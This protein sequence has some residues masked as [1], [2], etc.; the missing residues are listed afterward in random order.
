[1]PPVRQKLFWS[2]LRYGGVIPRLILARTRVLVGAFP[3][4]SQGGVHSIVRMPTGCVCGFPGRQLRKGGT[5]LLG[6]I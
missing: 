3:T 2:T 1:M 5:R 6:A 4:V